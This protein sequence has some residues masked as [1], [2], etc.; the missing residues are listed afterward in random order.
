MKA[1]G[2][3]H[4]MALPANRYVSTLEEVSVADFTRMMEQVD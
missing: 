3:N 2:V 4:K 1:I